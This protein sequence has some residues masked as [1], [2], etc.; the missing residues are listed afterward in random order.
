[1][2][3]KAIEREIAV[4]KVEQAFGEFIDRLAAS[5]PSIDRGNIAK[6]A[7]NYFAGMIA[8]VLLDPG[9][10]SKSISDKAA[11][12]LGVVALANISGN[13]SIIREIVS[14]VAEIGG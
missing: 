7:S 11:A 14:K 9:A 3:D 13:E 2:D 4:G 5:N 12:D 6:F 8:G 1:M 10:S